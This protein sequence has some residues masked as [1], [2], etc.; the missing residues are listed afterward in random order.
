[1]NT[2][3]PVVRLPGYRSKSPGLIHCATDFLRSSGSG[4]GS[5]KA[6]EYN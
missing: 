2:G 5:T 1:M 6:R 3:G 4:T